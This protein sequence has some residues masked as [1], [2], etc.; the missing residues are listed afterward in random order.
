MKIRTF[1]FLVAGLFVLAGVFSDARL[2]LADHPQEQEACPL[3]PGVTPP[4]GPRVTAQQV[5]DGSATLK[6][7]ALAVRDRYKTPINPPEA[8]LYFQCRVREEGSPYRSGSTY[9]VQLTLDG[10]VYE[11]AKSMSL[12]GPATPPLDLCR[13]PFCAGRL[14]SR[15]G[16]PGFPGPCHC[17]ASFPRGFSHLVAR[18]GRRIRCDHP[19][20]RPATWEY[21]ALPAMP[22]YFC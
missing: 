3:P 2:A 7:F 16:Q 22:P 5:E 20:S 11:H 6:E 4:A 19:Y 14:P 18:T 1:L 12:S 17:P 21:Q 13:D 10:R 8:A 9:L 15:S